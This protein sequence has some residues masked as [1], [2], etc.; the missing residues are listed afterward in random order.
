MTATLLSV[1]QMDVLHTLNSAG[2]LC[3]T[4]GEIR[5]AIGQI[6]EAIFFL[7]RKIYVI[8]FSKSNE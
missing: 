1:E 8:S 6:K 2:T 4:F 7:W 5:S 3:F